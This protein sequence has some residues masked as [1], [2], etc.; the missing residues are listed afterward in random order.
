M[1]ISHT[2][3]AQ[4]P[5]SRE[6]QR[7]SAS[8]PFSVLLTVALPSSGP[9]LLRVARALAPPDRLH[10]T[11]L[12]CWPEDRFRAQAFEGRAHGTLHEPLGP[13][14][15][16]AGE[17]SV[18][19]LCFV[20]ADVGGDIVSIAEERSA[21]LVLMGWH[22]PV[23]YEAP[24]SGPVET[25]LRH[26]PADVAVYLARQ[27]RPWRSVLVPYFG[28]P[29]DRAALEMARRI[30]RHAGVRV[31][32]LH[33]VPPNRGSG[34][35]RK[36]LSE[37]AEAFEADRIH[38]KIVE[39]AEP[40]EAVVAEAWKGYDLMVVGASE[41]W[42]LEASLFTNR[43]ERLAFATAASLLVVRKGGYIPQVA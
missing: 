42:G 28:G 13:L 30:A 24:P 11:A 20:S 17:I 8:L 41:T 34:A 33:V 35:P 18:D 26:A 2:R 27:F 7:A 10:V 14:L 31:T 39:H 22:A 29:H 16:A 15:E 43:H 40:V 1:S 21:D 19:P 37:A 6:V 12:H 5:D 32:I 23:T 25:V 38:L 4:R 3:S 36:G 9:E